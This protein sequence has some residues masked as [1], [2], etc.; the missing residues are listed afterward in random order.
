MGVRGVEP[1][2]LMATVL[3]TAVSPGTRSTPVD[4][5]LSCLQRI[6][7]MRIRRLGA[8]GSS[9]KPKRPPGI[10]AGGLHATSAGMLPTSPPPD[11]I[12]RRAVRQNWRS[13]RLFP[14]NFGGLP[15]N[16]TSWTPWL[17]LDMFLCRV[18]GGSWFFPCHEWYLALTLG[19]ANCF[20]KMS[21]PLNSFAR[22]RRTIQ[23]YAVIGAS[24]AH[25]PA[26]T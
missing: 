22:S 21:G 12:R 4:A 16:T 2:I 9:R 23:I 5:Q 11:R 17:A 25:T 20:K 1:P 26:R 6:A 18:D 24:F 7:C 14:P 19:Q 15:T 13:A 3:R 8:I 10:S